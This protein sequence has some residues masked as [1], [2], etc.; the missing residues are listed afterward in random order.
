[1]VGRRLPV[2]TRWRIAVERFMARI[3][4][5]PAPLRAGRRRRRPT[6]PCACPRRRRQPSLPMSCRSCRCHAG[7]VCLNGGTGTHMPPV[8]QDRDGA[9]RQALQGHPHQRCV[10]RASRPADGTLTGQLSG[11]GHSFGSRPGG[12]TSPSNIP[13][14]PDRDGAFSPDA[15][16]NASP[17]GWRPNPQGSAGSVEPVTHPVALPALPGGGA[18]CTHRGRRF[19]NVVRHRVE[20]LRGHPKRPASAAARTHLSQPATRFQAPDQI[21]STLSADP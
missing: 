12:R 5:T 3:L 13:A 15:R 11:A 6:R 9:S 21:Q 7:P 20:D 18:S 19:Q 8:G 10:R 2:P 17:K 4:R 1:V 14:A 16:D